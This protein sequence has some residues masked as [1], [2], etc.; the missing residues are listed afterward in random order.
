MSPRKPGSKRGG[1]KQGTEDRGRKKSSAADQRRHRRV[2]VELPIDY[3]RRGIKADFGGIVK[4]ASEGG[5]LVYL[6]EKMKVGET[7]KIEIYFPKGLE[8]Q[9]IQGLAKIVWADLASKETWREHRYGLKFHRLPPKTLQKLKSLLKEMEK[10]EQ[11][12]DLSP[13]PEPRT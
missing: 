9:T 6:P 2:P 5:I 1:K 13:S 8:L 7:L 4:N 10:T 11:A 12:E 3:A